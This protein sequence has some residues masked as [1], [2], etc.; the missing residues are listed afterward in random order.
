[1]G[2]RTGRARMPAWRA[3]L[4]GVRPSR[5][6][7][8]EP[9]PGAARPRRPRHLKGHA[10]G[11]WERL[12]S[13]ADSMRVLTLADGPMLEAT[14]SA[15]SEYRSALEACETGGQYYEAKTASGA[16]M[17]RANP[18]AATA[19]DAWRRYVVGLGHFGLSPL[20]R[21]RVAKAPDTGPSELDEWLVQS[22]PAKDSRAV[23]RNLR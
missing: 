4:Q 3:K 21:G 17:L 14:C 15:Y 2:G 5:L 19:A 23:L 18:A 13:L 9:E 6:N 8:R 10:R 11:E 20:M 16:V 1:M 22:A 12:A 7:A